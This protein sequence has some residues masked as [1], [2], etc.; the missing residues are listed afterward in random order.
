MQISSAPSN[1]SRFH[2][3]VGRLLLTP[4]PSRVLNM[5]SA[6]TADGFRPGR[7]LERQWEGTHGRADPE[8]RNYSPGRHLQQVRLVAA[9]RR[10]LFCT[11]GRRHEFVRLWLRDVRQMLLKLVELR[12][13]DWGRVRDA[14]A[15]SNATPDNDPNYFMVRVGRPAPPRPVPPLLSLLAPHRP[16]SPLS[17]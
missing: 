5:C 10:F 6:F 1:C 15:A 7:R 14:A 16:L 13:S 17:E 9:L 3:S 11:F 8:D 4:R 12:S 2:D